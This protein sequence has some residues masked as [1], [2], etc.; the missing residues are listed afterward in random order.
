MGAYLMFVKESR[1]TNCAAENSEADVS[2]ETY[3]KTII[4]GTFVLDVAAVNEMTKD[5][6]NATL[7]Q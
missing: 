5:H 6:L 1:S 3:G 4:T 2:F 7:E